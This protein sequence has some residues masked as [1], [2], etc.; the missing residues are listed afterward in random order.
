[1]VLL[2][3]RL[4]LLLLLLLSMLLSLAWVGRVVFGCHC[5]SGGVSGVAALVG[6][7]GWLAGCFFLQESQCRSQSMTRRNVRP[8]INIT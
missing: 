1:M 3:L 2:V 7:A 5:G 6:L 4:L 8:S